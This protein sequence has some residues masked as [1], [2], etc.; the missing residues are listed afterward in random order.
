MLTTKVFTPVESSS[1]P[2]VKVPRS[3]TI[4]NIHVRKTR[5]LF[6][7][8]VRNMQNAGTPTDFVNAQCDGALVNSFN[9]HSPEADQA[10]FHDLL[11]AIVADSFRRLRHWRPPLNCSS[12]D[13]EKELLQ[14]A[15]LSALEAVRDFN[16]AQGIAFGA[17]V[18]NRIR[19]GSR[20]WHRREKSHSA[21]VIS[22]PPE[23]AFNEDGNDVQSLTTG[24][25]SSPPSDPELFLI[26]REAIANLTEQQHRVIHAY[27]WQGYNE[28]EIGA[29]E[30]V[31]QDTVSERKRAALRSLQET[32]SKVV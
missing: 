30:G 7:C 10:S 15:W 25:P 32:L 27:F 3:F 19:S 5:G 17:F 18:Y 21:R 29:E 31:S 16:P 6:P 22:Q 23:P 24:M 26:L 4:R 1:L 8:E 9:G 20:T 13:W 2:A 12:P 14:V 28:T 11:L